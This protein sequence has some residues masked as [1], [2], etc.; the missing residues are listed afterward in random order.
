MTLGQTFRISGGVEPLLPLTKGTVPDMRAQRSRPMGGWLMTYGK[1]GPDGG[2]VPTVDRD[3]HIA[4]AASQLGSID[5]SPFIERGVWNDNHTAEAVGIPWSLEFH[6]G[7]TALSQ[8]HRK[9]GF[10]TTGWLFDRRDPESWRGLLDEDG[11]PRRPT[12]TEFDRADYYYECA[13]AL[14]GTPRP[15]GFSAE[16]D[17][18]LSPC[19]TRIVWARVRKASVCDLPRN[20]DS[21]TE[22]LVQGSPLEQL[23]KGGRQ[24]G[25]CACPPTER[26]EALL[27]GGA[28]PA[29]YVPG[30]GGEWR[31]PAL[32][33]PDHLQKWRRAMVPRMMAL[34]RLTEADA[35]RFLDEYLETLGG[36]D[37]R[38]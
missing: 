32:D 19:R 7:T 31:P 26:C 13:Q 24:C 3:G 38:S 34:W 17:M 30:R 5:W 16:G 2:I 33:N 8:S 15:I 21:T 27:K 1:I 11:R 28:A 4:E 25:R 18:V 20:P 12:A 10:W 37:A 35:S 22:L 36:R 6:D 14:A 9:V 29:E 23:R